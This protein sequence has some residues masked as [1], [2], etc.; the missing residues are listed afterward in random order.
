MN[1]QQ[2]NRAAILV[3]LFGGVSRL[4]EAT[5]LDKATISRWMSDGARGN[6]GRV[7]PHFN[8]VIMAAGWRVGIH[9]N[10]I[11]E[12][13][14]LMICPCCKQG[15]NTPIDLNSLPNEVRRFVKRGGG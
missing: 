1:D 8:A 12:C 4:A 3:G 7:P 15:L 6:H 2:I 5:D 11:K 9:P 14:D 10:K 13:L